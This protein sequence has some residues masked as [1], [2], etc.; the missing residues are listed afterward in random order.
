MLYSTKTPLE[1][2]YSKITDFEIFQ[3]YLGKNFA[4]HTRI[5]SPLREDNNP[6]FSLYLNKNNELRFKDFKT[7]EGGS[8]VEFIKI[9]YTCDTVNAVYH[10]DNDLNLGLFNKNLPKNTTTLPTI[11]YKE[12]PKYSIK[13]SKI[14]WTKKLYEYWQQFGISFNTLKFYDVIP[15]NCFWIGIK[16]QMY[17][18]EVPF[19]SFAYLLGSR[20]KIYSPLHADKLLKFRGNAN[21]NTIQGWKQVNKTHKYLIITSSLKEVM[22]LHEL[23]YTA[24]APNSESSVINKKFIE[25]FKKFFNLVIMYDF[26]KAGQSLS[27]KHSE[28]YQCPFVE[29]SNNID[30]DL[31][32]YYKNNGKEATIKLIN[33]I[34]KKHLL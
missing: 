20:I 12:R 16:Y 28:I 31:S 3:H 33:K 24:I 5:N 27:K 21:E 34:L 26:D 9:K 8:A 11:F 32:D 18:N 10:I 6:S 14:N 25:L 22:L 4:I 1:K 17:K 19:P 13:I 15:I 30:K 2:L 23:G 29:Y 7:G